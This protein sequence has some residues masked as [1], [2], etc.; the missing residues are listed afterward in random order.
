MILPATDSMIMYGFILFFIVSGLVIG[1]VELELTGVQQEFDTDGIVD[2]SKAEV[3]TSSIAK[4]TTSVFVVLLSVLKMATWTFGSIPF[5]IEL[6][7][8]VPI[9]I[10]F[11]FV[12]IKN[13]LGS[14]S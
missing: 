4:T 10:I 12:V 2:D 11:Y 1:F 6:I 8:M 13:I 5:L 14:G 9:R 3:R 7:I